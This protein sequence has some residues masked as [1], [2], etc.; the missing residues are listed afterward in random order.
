MKRGFGVGTLEVS[1]DEGLDEAIEMF[2]KDEDP[3]V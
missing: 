2:W 1:L 3:K